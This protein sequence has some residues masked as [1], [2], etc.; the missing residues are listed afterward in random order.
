MDG[1][2]PSTQANAAARARRAS[3]R[4]LGMFSSW[5]RI[6]VP[7]I[8]LADLTILTGEAAAS[9]QERQRASFPQRQPGGD[10]ESDGEDG[11]DS[12]DENDDDNGE[13]K[14]PVYHYKIWKKLLR[15]GSM[16]GLLRYG[17]LL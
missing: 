7:T 2:G 12:G 17:L 3:R 14:P 5:E 13:D 1:P 8:A 6:A 15:K 16:G 10:E 4:A 9:A 11:D